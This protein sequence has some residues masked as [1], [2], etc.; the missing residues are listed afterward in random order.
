MFGGIGGGSIPFDPSPLSL[1]IWFT[2]AGG[3]PDLLEHEDNEK[4]KAKADAN[5]KMEKRDDEASHKEHSG[6]HPTPNSPDLDEG[7]EDVQTEKKRW[8]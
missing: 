2:K 8:A 4:G 7:T 6:S 5:G 3:T 1:A